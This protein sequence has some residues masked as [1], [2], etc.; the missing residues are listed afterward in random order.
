MKKITNLFVLTTLALV[1]ATSCDDQ[2]QNIENRSITPEFV[3]KMPESL[4]NIQVTVQNEK[5]DIKNVSTGRISSYTSLQDVKLPVGLYDMTYSADAKVPDE[6]KVRHITAFVQSIELTPGNREVTLQA[7]ENIENNDF[8]IQEIFFTGTLRPS[9]R[10]YNGDDYIII[11]NNTDHVLYADGLSI[12]ESYFVTTRKYNYTPNI[13]DRSMT[14]QAIYTI[15]GNGKEHPVKPGECLRIVDTGIDHRVANPNSFDLSDADFEWFDV[16]TVPA[17]LDIDGPTVPNLDRWFCY[18]KSFFILHNRGFRAWALARIPEEREKYLKE[19]LYTFTY[20]IVVEA[21]S[22]PMQQTKYFIPNEW[23]V[24][25]VNC[26]VGASYVW[27]VTAPSLDRGWTYC[28]NMDH[29][30][31]RYFHSVRRKMMYLK[32]GR[33]VLQDTNNSTEDFNP[34]CIPSE[35]ENQGSAID[36]KGTKCTTK[37]WD[38]VIPKEK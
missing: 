34:Y 30:K 1:M 37:T 21:G 29:D 23:I 10:Q 11:F 5:I 31:T 26:S 7:Y 22:Y 4:G 15:P 9:G 33:P 8:I 28:G 24:D 19:Y 36:M 27:N 32:D 13:M 2:V 20:D 3:V 25:A 35:I 14:V 6:S 12:L 17:H 16:S 18:T 38:G